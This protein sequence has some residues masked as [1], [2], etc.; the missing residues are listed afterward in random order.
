MEKKMYA[1]VYLFEGYDDNL[2]YSNVLG[3]YSNIERARA[4]MLENVAIDCEVLEDEDD[5][6]FG[7]R[8]FE[9]HK[10]YE[11]DVVLHHKVYTNCY[12]KY[13]IQLVD[14]FSK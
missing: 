8:N 5:E 6:F 2:P 7:Y 3:V 14:V 12:T 4:E 1:V 13:T 11:N 10:Q 9:I